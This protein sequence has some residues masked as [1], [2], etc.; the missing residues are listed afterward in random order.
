MKDDSGNRK[1]MIKYKTSV[2][3]QVYNTED[4]LDECI[5]SVLNQT[6]KEVELILIDDGSTDGS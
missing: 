1:E 6:Q 4:F 3:V 5:Q 2:I